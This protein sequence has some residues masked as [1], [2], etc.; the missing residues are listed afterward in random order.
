MKR[1]LLPVL[2][3]FSLSACFPG[4]S[5]TPARKKNQKIEAQAG[6]VI[7]GMGLTIDADYDPRL[8]N[9]IAGYKLLPVEIK[10]TSLRNIP[11]LDKLDRWVIVGE[12]GQKYKAVNSLRHK[13]PRLWREVP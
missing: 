8:D 10:N 9:V 3:L 6:R 13:D 11:M 2:L 5:A 7:A 1:Y 4:R 12:H